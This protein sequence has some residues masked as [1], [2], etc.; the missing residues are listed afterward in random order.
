VPCLRELFVVFHRDR[1]MAEISL[2][3]LEEFDGSNM[4]YEIA[5]KT[6]IEKSFK[7]WQEDG[8]C[9]SLKVHFLV[10]GGE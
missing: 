5:A 2:D 9:G 6:E 7:K 3:Y 8:F 1:D 10:K 4:G